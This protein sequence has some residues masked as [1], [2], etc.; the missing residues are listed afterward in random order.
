MCQSS[1]HVSIVGCYVKKS[2]VPCLTQRLASRLTPFKKDYVLVIRE[3]DSHRAP[4]STF[5]PEITIPMFWEQF[6][7]EFFLKL[8][9]ST[10]ASPIAA[11]G[12]TATLSTS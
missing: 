8:S 9:E 12:S 2:V 7:R 11:L 4:K 1:Q 3:S 5:P 6:Q 10:A